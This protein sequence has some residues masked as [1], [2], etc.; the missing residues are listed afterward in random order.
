MINIG[1]KIT[2][3][4]KIL[5]LTSVKALKKTRYHIETSCIFNYRLRP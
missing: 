2:H 3:L 1:L 4:L 5:T